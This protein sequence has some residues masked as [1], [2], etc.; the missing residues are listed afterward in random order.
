MKTTRYGGIA[1]AYAGPPLGKP[2]FA[3]HEATSLKG[4]PAIVWPGALLDAE[5]GFF[6][7]ARYQPVNAH[8]ETLV[9]DFEVNEFTHCPRRDNRRAYKDQSAPPCDTP[10]YAHASRAVFCAYCLGNNLFESFSFHVSFPPCD[11]RPPFT[12]VRE[13]RDCLNVARRNEVLSPAP[14][15]R[16]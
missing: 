11:D 2:F 15:A 7:Q 9:R 1:P 10:P 13:V 8:P 6:D 14:R 3:I 12:W 5:T 4:R 16:P